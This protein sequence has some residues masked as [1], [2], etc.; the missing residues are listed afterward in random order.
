MRILTRQSVEQRSGFS[1]LEMLMAVTI[2]TVITIALYAIFDQTQRAFRAGLAQVDVLEA[3][4]A[5]S[6]IID[7]DIRRIVPNPLEYNSGRQQMDTSQGFR[8]YP[9]NFWIDDYAPVSYLGGSLSQGTGVLTALQNVFF[10]H[11]RN[12]ELTAIGYYNLPLQIDWAGGSKP[13][14][15]TPVSTLYRYSATVKISTLNEAVFTRLLN[16]FLRGPLVWEQNP[17]T[18]YQFQEI[19][20]GVV[21]NR[22]SPFGGNGEWWQLVRDP[23]IRRNPT[24]RTPL[25]GMTAGGNVIPAQLE[26]ELMILEDEILQQYIIL[27]ESN[28]LQARNF[29]EEHLQEIHFFR[30]R[31]STALFQ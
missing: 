29:L 26:Y 28:S 17:T 14:R 8:N 2:T 24:G 11:Q 15:I 6:E 5:T 30:K 31:I 10:F 16:N 19:V 18:E 9:F 25:I 20:R 21:H 1:L 27:A 3:G 7:S 22:W 23:L 4:R 12:D 13:P